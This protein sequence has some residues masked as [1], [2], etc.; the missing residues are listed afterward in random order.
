M[1]RIEALK[2][3]YPVIKDHLVVTNM[4]GVAVELYSLGHRRNFFYLE[5]SM[6]LASSIGLGLALCLP[7]HQVVVLDGDGSV[8][9]NLGTFSTMARYRP[10]NLT[11]VIFDNGSYLSVGG[12]PTATTSGTDLEAVAVAS[13]VEHAAKVDDVEG[14]RDAL[15]ATIQRSTLGVL[16]A[17]VDAVGPTSFHMDVGLLEN[18][19]EFERYIKGLT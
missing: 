12:F 10:A 1:Q 5:H 11:H 19:F 15:D 2:A 18:R 6:G 8:L 9:M 17:K 13:G 16:V 3:I 7:D 4:G 14:L